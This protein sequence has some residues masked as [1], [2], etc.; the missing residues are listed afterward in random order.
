MVDWIVV[1]VICEIA[2]CLRLL[3][4][5]ETNCHP[6]FCSDNKVNTIFIVQSSVSIDFVFV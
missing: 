6:P 3:L 5:P 4:V 2:F 1:G